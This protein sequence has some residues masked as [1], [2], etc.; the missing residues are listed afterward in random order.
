MHFRRDIGH[1]VDWTGEAVGH[2]VWVMAAMD[3][4]L[5]MVDVHGFTR[6]KTSQIPCSSCF[7]TWFRYECRV[8]D[9]GCLAKVCI[10]ST[11]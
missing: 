2:T 9:P 4:M 10:R 8:G 11:I 3:A 1:K 7:N 6:I 5:L